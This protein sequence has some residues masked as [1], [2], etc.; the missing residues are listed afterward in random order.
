MSRLRRDLITPRYRHAKQLVAWQKEMRD[1]VEKL[2]D[3]LPESSDAAEAERR[4][5]HYQAFRAV[6]DVYS[7]R[8]RAIDAEMRLLEQAE[9]FDGETVLQ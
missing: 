3:M 4:H 7:N 6:D 2:L 5:L 9:E 1:H 8:I